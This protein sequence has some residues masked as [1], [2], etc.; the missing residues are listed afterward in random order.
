VECDPGER[1]R[2]RGRMKQVHSMK[3][4]KG[5]SGSGLLFLPLSWQYFLYVFWHPDSGKLIIFFM[6]NA[7]PS[8][9]LTNEKHSD[10]SSYLYSGN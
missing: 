8:E 7:C 6:T 2:E 9:G 10:K 1:E 3:W 4:E 5:Q